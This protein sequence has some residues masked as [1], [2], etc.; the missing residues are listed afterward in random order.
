MLPGADCLILA[1]SFA[2]LD[3]E[4]LHQGSSAE[5]SLQCVMLSAAQ[6]RCPQRRETLRTR[7]RCC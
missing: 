7:R 5:I 4:T 3:S 6:H 2:S 1:E